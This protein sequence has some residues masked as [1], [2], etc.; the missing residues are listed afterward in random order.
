MKNADV[1]TV[2]ALF[3]SDDCREWGLERTARFIMFRC[4]LST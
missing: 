1:N 3:S 2:I 4:H